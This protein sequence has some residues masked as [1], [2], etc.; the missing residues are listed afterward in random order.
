MA[1]LPGQ[2]L[3]GSSVATAVAQISPCRL[4]MAPHSI[5]PENRP[6]ASPS[7]PGAARNHFLRSSAEGR[8]PQFAAAPPACGGRFRSPAAPACVSAGLDAGLEQAVMRSTRTTATG[9]VVVR[10]IA[11]ASIQSAALG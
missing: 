4:T 6:P 9:D 7:T 1:W 5:F 2:A 8:S 10:D 11:V 3:A